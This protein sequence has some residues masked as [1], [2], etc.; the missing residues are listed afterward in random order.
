MGY[1]QRGRSTSIRWSQS[2]ES[3]GGE[4]FAASTNGFYVSGGAKKKRAADNVKCASILGGSFAG[5]LSGFYVSGGARSV[6][7]SAKCVSVLGGSFAGLLSGF[8]V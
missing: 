8:Y 3:F 7:A 1:K 2:H 5:L 4:V 6:A